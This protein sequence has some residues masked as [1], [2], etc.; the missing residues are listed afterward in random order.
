MTFLSLHAQNGV[1]M[2]RSDLKP[3]PAFSL[4]NSKQNRVLLL[5]TVV[6]FSMRSA[7]SGTASPSQAVIAVTV[8]IQIGRMTLDQ[9][10]GEEVV[11]RNF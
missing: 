9:R 2:C 4:F 1:R 7:P 10:D 8:I 11:W 6:I 3:S 5:Y